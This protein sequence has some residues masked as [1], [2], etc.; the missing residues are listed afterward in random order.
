MSPAFPAGLTPVAKAISRNNSGD[1]GYWAVIGSIRRCAAFCDRAITM[2]LRESW[3]SYAGRRGGLGLGEFCG[4]RR[5]GLGLGE[6]CGGRHEGLGLGEFC[7]GRRGGLGLGEFCGGRREGRRNVVI[8]R[9]LTVGRL[10][11]DRATEHTAVS[12]QNLLT[13]SERSMP[14]KKLAISQ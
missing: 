11:M 10:F 8:V 4:G 13:T 3:G 9:V 7:G 1:L 14:F 12:V 2:T 5:E 6:F